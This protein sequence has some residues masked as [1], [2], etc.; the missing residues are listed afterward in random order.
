MEVSNRGSK[1]TFTIRAIYE[2]GKLR[3]LE[4]LP[5]HEQESVLLHGDP[6]KRCPGDRGDFA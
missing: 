4:L 1:A 3:P 6:A 5:L 2:E